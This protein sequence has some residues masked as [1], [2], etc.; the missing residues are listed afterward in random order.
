MRTSGNIISPFFRLIRWPNL[1][2]VA[3]T[4]W[5]IKFVIIDPRLKEAGMDITLNSVSLWLLI[6]AT[7]MV[8][9]AGYIINDLYD[10]EIDL[11]NKPEKVIIYQHIG[12]KA[13]LWIVISLLFF[14]SLL[15]AYLSQF[16]R[17]IWIYFLISTSLLW[18]Y[19]YTLKKRALIGNLAI[20]FLCGLVPWIVFHAET[21][22]LNALLQQ[23]EALYSQLYGII[24]GYTI[25]AFFST[26]YREIIKDLEDMEG[27]AKQNCRTLPIVI[28]EFAAKWMALFFGG[29]L[30]AV[31]LVAV[32]KLPVFSH[33]LII[34]FISGL[35]LLPLLLSFFWLFK[36]TKKKDYSFLSQWIKGIMGVGLLGLVV[37]GVN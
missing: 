31:L 25:F 22:G 8:T 32:I 5:L 18:L 1:L 26:V 29:I 33:P 15:F 27:D 35:V 30:F 13:A 23:N 2:I 19:S 24:V 20:G 3:I 17:G 10:Y 36:A 14:S 12:E 28:G 6:L 4:Q 34:A 7:V 11:I 16:S 9:A 37:L 21:P